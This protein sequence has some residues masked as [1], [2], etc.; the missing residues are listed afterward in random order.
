MEKMLK[1]YQWMFQLLLSRGAENSWWL[2][3]ELTFTR[4]SP[5][6]SSWWSWQS[7]R[8]W[9]A[10]PLTSLT[11]V[12]KSSG[13]LFAS[14][15]LSP[16]KP[17][18]LWELLEPLWGPLHHRAWVWNCLL[19]DALP[20]HVRSND[21]RGQDLFGAKKIWD[22][23]GIHA[24]PRSRS[25]VCLGWQSSCRVGCSACSGSLPPSTPWLSA[26]VTSSNMRR[27]LAWK[28]TTQ[29]WQLKWQTSWGS[30]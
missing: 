21:V 26:L 15:F 4:V 1:V 16:E 6:G 27:P 23:P 22:H 8:S 3:V 28:C 11:E 17:Q 29:E 14:S 10:S 30:S 5:P 25:G 12:I 2:T 19:Q 9:S 7:S 24:T 20:H 13:I 18:I